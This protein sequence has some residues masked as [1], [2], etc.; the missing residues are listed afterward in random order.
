[1]DA[2]DAVAKAVARLKALAASRLVEKQE[3]E[4][5]IAELAEGDPQIPALAAEL[6]A[7][8]QEYRGAM[9]EIVELRKLAD[10]AEHAAARGVVSG[11]A[12]TDPFIKAPEDVALD[13]VRGHLRDLEGRIKVNEELRRMEE[14]APAEKP[15]APAPSREERDA[16]ARAEFEALRAKREQPD[17]P[18]DPPPAG[19]R[20]RTI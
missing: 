11:D 19:P 4:A 10:Q 5:R 9:A 8:D 18:E 1:M 20:K 16:A 3:L 6:A 12:D 15:P 7:A 14:P 2:K 17:D 13:N